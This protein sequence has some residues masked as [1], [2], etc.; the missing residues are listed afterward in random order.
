MRIIEWNC[1]GAFRNKNKE[2]LELK[3]DILIIPECEEENKLKFGT[4][5]PKPNDFKWIG[6]SGKKGVGIFSFSNY[7]FKILKEYNPK[8]RYVI[9]LEVT[10]GQNTFILFAVWAM[11]DKK[12]PLARYIGQIWLAIN[13]YKSIFSED[14][15]I[16]GDFN[17]NQI[18][19]E[20][21]R[22]GNHTDV[23]NF[24]NE[25]QV[26]SLYHK[27][28]NENHGKEKLS[29]F[30]MYRNIEKPY[31]IDYVFA[32]HNLIK[33]GFNLKLENHNNWIDKS[34]HIP[35]ILDLSPFKSNSKTLEKY[36]EII[37]S[38]LSDL[39]PETKLKFKPEFEKIERTACE[40]D[41]K[42]IGEDE[43][44][45]LVDKIEVLKQIDELSKRLLN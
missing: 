35:L 33:N 41:N 43:F 20:K 39:S 11:N 19:D 2:I 22:V 44:L 23:V 24:L 40:I 3:P 37:K 28:Y 45:K 26:E 1:Q 21:D 13:Y 36:Y 34:D 25:F 29:T 14:I 7:Q 9:P 42:E 32:S 18:W 30:F 31:H 12:N 5:T 8:Y 27:Q 15:I 16:M 17:S 10:N 38:K 6:E 4:L